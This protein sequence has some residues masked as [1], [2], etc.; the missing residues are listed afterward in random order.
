MAEKQGRLSSV[1]ISTDG[2]ATYAAIGSLV[3]A[4]FNL[5]RST[6]DVTDRG[7]GEWTDF[8]PGRKSGTIDLTCNWN[9]ADAALVSLVTAF[10]AEPTTSLM[11]R[12]RP[13]T[14]AGELS[15]AASC[16]VSALSKSAP[17]E[18]K[19]SMDVTLQITGAVAKT[20]Q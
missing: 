18:D 3:D 16:F 4:T 12:F 13:D 9:V 20:A 15:Y 8:L 10:Y 14:V 17:G 2:G 5:D 6:I 1:A 7:S 11:V 19:V